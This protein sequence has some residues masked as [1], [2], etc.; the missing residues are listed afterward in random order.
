MEGSLYYL[1]PLGARSSR[2][3]TPPPVALKYQLAGVD[4]CLAAWVLG[5]KNPNTFSSLDPSVPSQSGC[6]LCPVVNCS[7]ICPV[8][9]SCSSCLLSLHFTEAS[10][11]HLPDKLLAFESLYPQKPRQRQKQVLTLTEKRQTL[12]FL[13]SSQDPKSDPLSLTLFLWPKLIRTDAMKH[14]ILQE[15]GSTLDS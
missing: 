2:E 4:K 12:D 5:W 3:L 13:D 1:N 9:A 15:L 11:H 14:E 6:H 10:W 7:I 8:F